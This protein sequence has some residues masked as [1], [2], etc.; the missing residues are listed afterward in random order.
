VLAEQV[1]KPGDLGSQPADLVIT[2]AGLVAPVALVT[3]WTGIAGDGDDRGADL[4]LSGVESSQSP[5]RRIVTGVEQAAPLAPAA[6][7]P[8]ASGPGRQRTTFM[9]RL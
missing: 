4:V 6:Y 7:R 3:A 2:R 8:T 5:G 9:L 1:S